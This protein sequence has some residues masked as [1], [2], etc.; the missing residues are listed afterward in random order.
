[1][2]RI[3]LLLVTLLIGSTFAFAQYTT[4]W[5]RPADNTLKS[6]TM[7][8][9]DNSD[10]VIVTGYIQSQNIYTRKYD[11]FGNFLWE[12]T[13]SSGIQSNY[14]KPMWINADINKNVFVVGYMYTFSSSKGR[15]YPSALVVLKYD[16]SGTL[17]WKKTISMSI[18]VNNLVSFSLRSEVDINGNLYIG[19]VATSPSGF[20]LV[21]LNPSGTTLF[22]KN[23]NLNAVSSFRSMR[24]KGNRVVLS[25][26][27][28]SGS[29][30]AAPVIVWDTNGNLL[31]SASQLGQSGI[32]VEMDDGGNVYVLT[33]YPNQFSAASGQ[34][35]LIYKLSSTGTQLWK[36]IYDF[37]GNDF[38]TRFTLVKDKIS[39]I[40]AGSVNSSYLDWVT[41]QI[42]TAGTRL[43]GVRYNGTTGNDE[44]PYFLTAKANGEVYVT[45]KG[46]P[47]FK[48]SNGS[49][50]L[51]MVTLKYGNTGAVKWLDTLNI[52]SGWGV[53]GTLASDSSLFV[54]SGTN[55]TAFHFIDQTGAA[56]CGIPTALKVTNVTGTS[57]TFSC[58]PVTGATLYHFRYK[59]T[60]ATIWT[61]TSSNLPS[62]TISGLS[63]GT[64]YT[65]AVEALCSS[66]PSGYSDSLTLTTSGTGYCTAGGQSTTQEYL[67]LVWIGG[68]TNQTLSNNG[69][70]DFTNLSSPL[71]QGSTVYGYLSAFLTYGLSEYYSIWIDYN[72]D[73]DF[74]DSGEQV[75]NISSDFMGYIA[76]NFTVPLSALPG[77]TRMRVMMR[78]GS[79]PVPCGLYSRGETEDYT[80]NITSN[81]AKSLSLQS[82][83]TE[84][85]NSETI[86]EV[87]VYPNPVNKGEFN[88]N[89]PDDTIFP[90]VMQLYSMAGQKVMQME[91]NDCSNTIKTD[92]L[93]NGLYILSVQINGV[94]KQ[95]KIQINR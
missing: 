79:T 15:E 5:I 71:A 85:F 7:I 37:G 29:L 62:V 11:K 13:S 48:Q 69:Y 20:V 56:S 42:N 50:Y 39:V 65:Y 89:L 35:I 64:S 81:T 28:T 51:R 60:S 34:D 43:W 30:S 92:G 8:A 27:G 47:S 53:A 59:T 77:P 36:K 93:I 40:G 52:Y 74:T 55:M 17:L 73:S 57:A 66:G 72:H 22:T 4:D 94:V 38:P 19:T 78:Y 33:S 3:A 83:N 23:S 46:G 67:N 84:K 6:G 2:V 41:F 49:S 12:R 80:V 1:M 91:L 9:R 70:G 26:N 45:G 54:L 44:Q 61:V 14:E 76:V 18:F 31:W 10:N 87:S 68:I 63:G 24:L 25:G 58:A 75:V 32:D 86:S 16:A 90:A 21:K 88:L 82:D 95:L